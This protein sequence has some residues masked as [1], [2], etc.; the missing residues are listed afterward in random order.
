MII[1][2]LAYAFPEEQEQIK[3]FRRL[4][5]F[6]CLSLS[7]CKLKTDEYIEATKQASRALRQSLQEDF[8]LKYAVLAL[9]RRSQSYSFR[10]LYHEARKDLSTMQEVL[11]KIS[12]KENSDNIQDTSVGSSVVRKKKQSNFCTR[13]RR[14]NRSQEIHVDEL[15]RIHSYRSRLMF[16][17]MFS[18]TRAANN[19]KNGVKSTKSR[20]H[21]VEHK[22]TCSSVK[23]SSQN[24]QQIGDFQSN[25]EEMKQ[26]I[27]TLLEQT[28]KEVAWC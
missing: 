15:E 20:G 24:K 25:D 4:E 9:H 16:Q 28:S 5:I 23:R 22:S 21:L 2:Y 18:K 26:Y 14:K 1:V 13:F 7:Q 10:G 8:D 12:S 17:R 6:A 11:D 3:R 19:T 27:D